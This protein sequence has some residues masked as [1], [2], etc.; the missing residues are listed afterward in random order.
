MAKKTLKQ[1]NLEY[2]EANGWSVSSSRVSR[3]L[4]LTKPGVK[5]RYFLGNAGAVRRGRT[6]TGSLS[7]KLKINEA[8]QSPKAPEIHDSKQPNYVSPGDDKPDRLHKSMLKAS[9]AD[10]Q[11]PE[12]T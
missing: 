9:R 11:V 12:I 8:G 3:Y 2:L 4:V 1:R 7:V 10:S 6:V 5:Y